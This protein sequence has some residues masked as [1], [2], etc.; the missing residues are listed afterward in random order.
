MKAPWSQRE[1]HRALVYGLGLSG[2]AAVRLLRSRG[3]EVVGVDR[4][5]AGELDLGELASDPGVELLL[6]REPTELPTGLDGVV[7]SPGV[8]AERPLLAAA[9]QQRQKHHHRADRCAAPCQRFC[10]RGMRQHRSAIERLRRG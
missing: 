2:L 9:R 1:W 6:G 10:G 8:P 3:V 5:A 4:R 7:V